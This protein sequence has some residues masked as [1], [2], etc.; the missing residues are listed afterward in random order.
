MANACIVRILGRHDR[1][2][3]ADT[4]DHPLTA[5]N[6]AKITARPKSPYQCFVSAPLFKTPRVAF[7]YIRSWFP[8]KKQGFPHST[9]M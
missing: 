6:Y 8:V 3:D 9:D 1:K 7:V 4:S 2:Y 5:G